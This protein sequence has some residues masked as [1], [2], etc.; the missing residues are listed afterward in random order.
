VPTPHLP[1]LDTNIAIG[2]DRPR[3]CVCLGRRIHPH[4]A[5]APGDWPDHAPHS[6]TIF[7]TRCES[8]DNR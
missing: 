3:L 6:V 1:H 4:Q 7:E 8:A 2:A 5:E